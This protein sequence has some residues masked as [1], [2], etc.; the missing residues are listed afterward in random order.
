MEIIS[1][2]AEVLGVVQSEIDK[3]GHGD[4]ATVRRHPWA[5]A[6]MIIVALEP[7]LDAPEQP[8]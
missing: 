1:D 8:A 7:S 3:A 5:P 4:K 2:N 6:G